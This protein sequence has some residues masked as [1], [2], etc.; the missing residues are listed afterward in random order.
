M[1]KKAAS[2]RPR[3]A[4]GNARDDDRQRGGEQQRRER[5]LDDAEGDDPGLPRAAGRRGAA[6][7]RGECE[8]GHAHDQDA[9]MTERV[10]ELAAQHEE[11]GEGEQIAVDDPLRGRRGER[12]VL[13][14]VGHGEGDD[15]LVDEHHR[16][17]EDH[18]HEDEPPVRGGRHSGDSFTVE[19]DA[20]RSICPRETRV[21]SSDI[22]KWTAGPSTYRRGPAPVPGALDAVTK[23]T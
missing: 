10:G 1:P 22:R 3:S 11:R 8:P 17:G 5:A 19:E 12:E 9:A 4:T 15:R 7:R 23:S 20:R 6:Q 16:H 21:F 2:A 14:Q 13:L 18:R